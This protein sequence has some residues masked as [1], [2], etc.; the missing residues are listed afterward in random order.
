MKE[1]NMRLKL[2]LHIH[3]EIT[4]KCNLKCLHCYQNNGPLPVE[5]KIKN[6]IVLEKIIDAKPFE[7]TITGGE[8]FLC[9]Y[10]NEIIK[11]LNL[12][13]ISP[14]ITSNGSKLTASKIKSLS[15]LDFTL[16]L[17]LDSYNQ[18]THDKIRNKD[19]VFDSVLIS[20]N[21]LCKAGIEPSISCCL[22]KYNWRDVA[23]LANL[24]S[25]FGITRLAVG[26]YVQGTIS[27]SIC[28]QDISIPKKNYP[29]Y[30]DLMQETIERFRGIVDIFWVS[31]W[32]FLYDLPNP[33]THSACSAM[34]RDLAIL[35]NGQVV[36]CPFIRSK[37]FYFGDLSC[38]SIK[39]I[40]NS[41]KVLKFLND[42]S[43]GC[44]DVSCKHYSICKSGCKAMLANIGNDICI[45]SPLCH[46]T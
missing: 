10:L 39:K 27:E 22:T 36:P 28:E 31:E 19:G 37:D 20:I 13:G 11:Q 3:W 12:V 43:K 38:S 6:F 34:D 32:A 9:D 5:D 35:A 15:S 41:E 14:L 17:S 8:P 16:Q 46:L 30:L 2:P 18:Q 23:K 29:E 21:K 40:W 26:E 7:V 24:L 42:K 45:K 25:E 1:L 44:S 33:P 4:S